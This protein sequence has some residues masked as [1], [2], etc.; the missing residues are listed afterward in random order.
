MLP[1]EM[2]IR[3]VVKD[4]ASFRSANGSDLLHLCFDN[5]T[6][7]DPAVVFDKH[8]DWKFGFLSFLLKMLIFLWNL[9]VFKCWL[10]KN[11]WS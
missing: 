9:P 3:E 10:K 8:F 5:N 2:A 11:A 7:Y 4:R 6:A 1:S